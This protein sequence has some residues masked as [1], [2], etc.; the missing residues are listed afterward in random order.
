MDVSFKVENVG[1][2]F[3]A[4]AVPWK[5]IYRH[6]ATQSIAEIIYKSYFLSN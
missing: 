4:A 6:A 2:E 3:Q 1:V 5:T